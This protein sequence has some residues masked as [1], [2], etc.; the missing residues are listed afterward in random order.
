NAVIS[1]MNR[2]VHK[3]GKAR[4]NVKRCIY[5]TLA[6]H[7]TATHVKNFSPPMVRIPC[8]EKFVILQNEKQAET[9]TEKTTHYGTSTRPPRRTPPS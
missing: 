4:L 3:P 9:T 6:G 5:Q 8:R 7:G 1:W 2:C